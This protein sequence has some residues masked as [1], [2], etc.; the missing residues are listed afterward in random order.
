M[1]KNKITMNMSP[2]QRLWLDIAARSS[3][4]LTVVL[5]LTEQCDLKCGHCF[6]PRPKKS[7][8]RLSFE[9]F[10]VLLEELKSLEVLQLILTGGEASIVPDFERIVTS[11]VQKRFMVRV[12]T[13][14][15]GWDRKKVERL[16][17]SGLSFIDVSM[18]HIEPE[19]HDAFVGKKGSWENTVNTIR[20]FRG[21]GGNVSVSL[22]AMNWNFDA[23]VPIKRFCDENGLGMLLTNAIH[24][25]NY[26]RKKPL[27][28]EMNEQQLEEIISNDELVDWANYENNFC[29]SG[30]EG[31][32][33]AGRET[34]CIKPNGDVQLCQRLNEK[35]GNIK[36][37]KFKDIWD[38]SLY[39]K[40]FIETKWSD[41]T[42]CAKCEL[43]W[44]CTR[45][46]ASA[47]MV[48]KD[49]YGK[50]SIDCKQ[51]AIAAKVFNKKR[52][53]AGLTGDDGEDRVSTSL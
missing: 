32:C 1:I 47:I 16:R 25:D 50:S 7:E 38:M 34:A 2:A 13:N 44:I 11:A 51:A 49:F 31:L 12:K 19:K 9:E 29:R 15:A 35:L 18:Y 30:K 41:L 37:T 26:G 6:V 23:I 52:V 28:Y 10:D 20:A 40:K 8:K 42:E 43:S 21:L 33:S 22:V 24:E 17:K 3:Y 39:R 45:C 48:D 36:R 27:E 46:P 14:A 5:V 4:P 53:A